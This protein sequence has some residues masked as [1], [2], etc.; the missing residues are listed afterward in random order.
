MKN[1]KEN[2]V[3]RLKLCETTPFNTWYSTCKP[4][5]LKHISEL[6]LR[7]EAKDKMGTRS[8]E[9]SFVACHF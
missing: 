7:T 4:L 1:R 9:M 8:L 3:W 6:F 2:S 5:T